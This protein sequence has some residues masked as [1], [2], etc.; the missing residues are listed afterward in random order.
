[1]A[2]GH[3]GSS[4]EMYSPT[5]PKLETINL[6]GHV[7]VLHVPCISIPTSNSHSRP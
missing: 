3:A 7:P 4:R 2:G 6:N 5:N 1:M